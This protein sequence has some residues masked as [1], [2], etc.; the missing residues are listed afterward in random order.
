MKEQIT[1]LTERKK[2]SLPEMILLKN[3]SVWNE[4]YIKWWRGRR[5]HLV[6]INHDAW[7]GLKVTPLKNEDE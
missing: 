5:R 7:K 2:K 1:W 6:M 4:E 3:N